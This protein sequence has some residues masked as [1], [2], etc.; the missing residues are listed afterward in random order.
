[1]RATGSCEKSA[2]TQRYIPKDWDSLVHFCPTA[3]CDFSEDCNLYLFMNRSYWQ[4]VARTYWQLQFS[5][6]VLYTCLFVQSVIFLASCIRRS[7]L[8]ADLYM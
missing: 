8:L 1:M 2:T 6:T 7:A 4:L 5:W 3:W